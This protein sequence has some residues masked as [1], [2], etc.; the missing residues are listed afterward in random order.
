MLE[1]SA[2]IGVEIGPAAD[3]FAGGTGA[4]NAKTYQVFG[5]AFL[6]HRP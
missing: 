6:A 1:E 2:F 3:V 5:Y 4:A